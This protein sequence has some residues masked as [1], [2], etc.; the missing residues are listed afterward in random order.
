MIAPILINRLSAIFIVAAQ[1]LLAWLIQYALE[2]EMLKSLA[3]FILYRMAYDFQ[4]QLRT[5]EE[6]S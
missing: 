3:A 1:I 5:E 4:A 2:I 6:R